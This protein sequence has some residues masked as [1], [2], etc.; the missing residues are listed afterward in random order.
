MPDTQVTESQ[1]KRIQAALMKVKNSHSSSDNAW[2][3]RDVFDG[4]MAANN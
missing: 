4:M 2:T 1:K 3:L